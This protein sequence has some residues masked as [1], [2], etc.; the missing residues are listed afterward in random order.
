MKP[1]LKNLSI[2]VFLTPGL[3]YV[4]EVR[5][6]IKVRIF[7]YMLSTL[8]IGLRTSFAQNTD[9]SRYF[10]APETYAEE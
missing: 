1:W 3:I 8:A 10:Q 7:D 2:I 5:G 6:H 9:G 4:E